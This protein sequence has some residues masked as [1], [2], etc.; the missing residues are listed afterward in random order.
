M[1]RVYEGTAARQQHGLRGEGLL[2]HHAPIT[3]PNTSIVT[4]SEAQQDLR[5]QW[6]VWM[7]H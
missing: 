6:F 2:R 1:V 4:M 3:T 5:S 7:R